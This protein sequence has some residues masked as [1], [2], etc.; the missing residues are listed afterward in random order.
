MPKP[1]P[2]LLEPARYPFRYDVDTRYADLD[3]QGHVNNVA[4]IEII[5]EG[6]LRF[7]R[8]SK[9]DE[10]L[11]GRLGMIASFSVDYLDVA[12]YL[13]PCSVHIGVLAI[14]RTSHTL[15]KLVTQNETPIALAKA[16]VVCVK[17]DRPVENDP[18]FAKTL[19][20]WLF[21]S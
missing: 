4:L 8:K 11:K 9:F 3:P 18:A 19:Q 17:D 6:R 2:V 10:A 1:D 21:N 16:V 12:Q 7:H 15:V 13:S 14:G 20:A 5:Q